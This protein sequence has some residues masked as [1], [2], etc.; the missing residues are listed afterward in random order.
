[1]RPVWMAGRSRYPWRMSRL[2]AIAGDRGE[3]VPLHPPCTE[4]MCRSIRKA[5]LLMSRRWV[6]PSVRAG[7]YWGWPRDRRCMSSI[8]ASWERVRC[9]PNR[10]AL[11]HPP[12]RVPPH[13]RLPLPR[14]LGQVRCG[15]RCWPSSWLPLS[16]QRSTCS[17]AEW[18]H[19]VRSIRSALRASARWGA[20]SLALRFWLATAASAWRV[21]LAQP[22]IWGGLPDSQLTTGRLLVAR[23]R[24][25]R[26]FWAL[27]SS[28]WSG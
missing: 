27:P 26:C 3:T 25:I 24:L 4:V 20:S 13:R 17:P 11:S 21:S 9:L 22:S 10:W 23:R 12:Q 8:A 1:M 6:P 16:P 19:R 5:M 28:L 15:R 18:P 14:A 2:V 7:P